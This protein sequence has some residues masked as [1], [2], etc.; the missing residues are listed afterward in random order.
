VQIADTRLLRQ[1]AARPS[2]ASGH[3]CGSVS[4]GNTSTPRSCQPSRPFA[5]A[6]IT[7]TSDK[8]HKADPTTALRVLRIGL[9][10]VIG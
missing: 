6:R 8:G 1:T 4:L 7:G 2:T 9:L 3:S 10:R 5:M